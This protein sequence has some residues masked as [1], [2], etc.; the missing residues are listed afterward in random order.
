LCAIRIMIEVYDDAIRIR[1][2]ERDIVIMQF[3]PI[4]KEEMIRLIIGNLGVPV[5]K[6]VQTMLDKVRRL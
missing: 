2:D 1:A 5:Y 3:D 6:Y 4:I